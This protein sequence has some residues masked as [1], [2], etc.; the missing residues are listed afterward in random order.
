MIANIDSLAD[1]VRVH[2]EHKKL[3]QK[4]LADSLGSEFNRT[5][6]AHLEQGRKL[7][8]DSHLLQKICEK[9]E[10]PKQIWEPFLRE[11]SIRR[12]NF[13]AILKELVGEAISAL[14]L[15]PTVMDVVEEQIKSLFSNEKPE[16]AFDIFN[17]VIIF[18]GVRPVT[19][20]FFD[21]YFKAGSF[22]SIDRF[23][24][25]V[26]TY[27][28]DAIRLFS[29][30]SEAFNTLNDD[31]KF[32][33]LLKPLNSND[34]QDYTQR[35]TWSNIQHINETQLPY[36]GYIAATRVRQEEKER[37]EL[38]VFLRDMANQKREN[39]FD[40]SKINEKTKRKMDSLLRKF[41]SKIENGLFS[42]LF[43]PDPALLD[44][45]ADYISPKEGGDIEKMAEAQKI[46]YR[47]LA[48]YLTADYMDVYVATSMRSDADFVSVNRFVEALFENED[49]EELKLRY[50]NPT[51]SWIEDRVAKG[52]VEALMLKRA[53]I[54]I[55]MAQKEDTFGKD[56]EASVTL[57]QG[58][59]VVVYV[60]KL[61][62]ETSSIDSE[63]FGLMERKDLIDLIKIEDPS[64]LKDIDDAADNESLHSKL[65]HLKLDKSSDQ[66]I[67]NI[68]R[69]HW[70]DYDI[71]G[72]TEKR[73]SNEQILSSSKTWLR[74]IISESK[75]SILNAEVRKELISILVANTIRFER[76]A[77]IFREVH[78][79]ALQVILST[80]VLNG[81]LVVRSMESCAQLI[82]ALIENKLDLE[83]T[84]DDDNY[85][86]IE[87]NTRSTIRVISRHKLLA[88][89][90]TTFY[91]KYGIG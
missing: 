39:K 44:K 51:Q 59:P 37:N 20:E 42:P 68:I 81:I 77:K 11:N 83:L 27:L 61:F 30:F 87:R 43:H 22:R 85:R 3:T 64:A 31:G 33:S 66:E 72:E 52:L 79:L 88:N 60:P 7:P 46:A 35:S 18:Y 49:I 17:S 50:F 5:T 54:C 38:A 71:F 9:L 89:A 47:N 1:Q 6:I 84:V 2:R 32:E 28:K 75:N 65:L 14:N 36:L 74:E 62:S 55:Y 12:A 41:N 86:L 21:K 8:H 4:Q 19:R 76:R 40:I 67:I 26:Q 15:D 13:E 90:F 25:A 57:G 73:I 78:P 48:N 53:N 16:H 91:K 56:S 58:K 45:E 24:E 23:N 10:I 80:G 70:A 69:K 63:K 82:R 29:T 34:I